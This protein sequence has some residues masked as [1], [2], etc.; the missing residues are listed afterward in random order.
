MAPYNREHDR[1][2]DHKV[3]SN[4]K[5]SELGR[6]ETRVLALRTKSGEVELR[7]QKQ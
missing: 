2:P 7:P 1:E 4:K 6:G 5:A 3:H